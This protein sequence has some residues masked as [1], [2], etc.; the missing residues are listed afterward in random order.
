MPPRNDDESNTP[1]SI[2][3]LEIN[4]SE[5]SGKLTPNPLGKK[6]VPPLKFVWNAL[7]VV[8]KSFDPVVPKI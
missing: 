5:P 6:F 8:G 4:I 1:P 7:D 2:F 3:N